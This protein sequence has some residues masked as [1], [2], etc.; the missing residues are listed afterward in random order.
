MPLLTLIFAKRE[1]VAYAIIALLLCTL[2]WYRNITIPSL[3]NKITELNNQVDTLEKNEKV[4]K[5]SIDKQNESIKALE[6]D[7]DKLNKAVV[8]TETLNNSL[9]VSLDEI[10]KQSK[11]YQVESMRLKTQMTDLSNSLAVQL[12]ENTKLRDSLKA[13]IKSNKQLTE[14][15]LADK[16]IT[17]FIDYQNIIDMNVER[18]NKYIKGGNK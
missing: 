3:E 16:V 15:E 6:L 7:K 13:V 11:R 4:L 12:T 18:N 8:D 1:Y 5:S 17:D 10:S 9:K 2:G 14:K